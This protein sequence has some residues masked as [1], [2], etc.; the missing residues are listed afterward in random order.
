MTPLQLQLTK[1]IGDKELTFGCY[2]YTKDKDY[3]WKPL[4]IVIKSFHWFN[5]SYTW[6]SHTTDNITVW[7][8]FWWKYN[9]GKIKP[10]CS[11]SK[12]EMEIIWHP[13]TLSDLHR[14]MNEKNVEFTQENNYIYPEYYSRIP[15]NSS[16]PLLEQ[17]ESTLEQIRDL[18]INNS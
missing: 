3:S 13:A 12:N 11:F 15:Y 1:L 14:W 6:Y 18:I 17:D 4:A 9:S 2:V 5:T 8:T 16:L 7:I 10:I